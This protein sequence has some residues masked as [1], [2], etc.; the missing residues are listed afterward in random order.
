MT[1][2]ALLVP[3]CGRGVGLGHLE[4][5][6]ALA[7][8]LR[9]D[10]SVSVVVP[11]NDTA[12][13][14]RVIDRG[15]AV[16]AVAGDIAGRA[17]TAA[18]ETSP[19]V[20][21]IDGY[22]FDVAAQLRLRA[23]APLILV[24]DRGHPAA[25]DLAINPAP[26]GESK[27]PDGADSFLGGAMYALLPSAVVEARNAAQDRDRGGRTVLVST[28]AMDPQ[29]LTAR[30]VADL[31]AGDPVIEVTAVV[32]PEMDAAS[33]PDDP[34][35][36]VLLAPATVAGALS[37]ATV[38]SGAAGTTAVQAACVGVPAVITPVVANQSDQA[39]ALAAAGCAL[40]APAD[41]LAGECV[42]LLDDPQRRAQMGRLG[43]DLVDGGGA[44]RVAGCV[45][46]LVH[47]RVR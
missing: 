33:L 14:R 45:R 10:V 31:L 25:C 17:L 29:G 30:L 39:A 34:R 43:R 32:G 3:D 16:L 44:A 4:R 15:H 5:M 19:D 26:G 12:V 36:A 27:R 42:R 2:L 20:L 22:S 1:A 8:A 40:V 38:F 37:L 46:R 9:A 21:V 6:L 28:G 11:E 23:R 18:K 13:H 47:A 24:D 35:L 41:Q 7:D